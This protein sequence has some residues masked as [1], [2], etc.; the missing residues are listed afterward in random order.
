MSKRIMRSLT[1]LCVLFVLSVPT[2]AAVRGTIQNDTPGSIEAQAQMLKDLKLFKGTDKGLELEKPMTRAEAAVMVTR[3]LG[4][5]AEAK[6]QNSPHPFGDVPNWA[7]AYVGWLYQNGLTKGISKTEYGSDRRVTCQQFGVFLTRA[8]YEPSARTALTAHGK[9]IGVDYYEANAITTPE[10]TAACD[11]AGFLRSDAVA[12]AVRLLNSTYV[13]GVDAGDNVIADITV[14]QALTERNVFTRDQFKQAAWSVLNRV[15]TASTANGRRSEQE[16]D[17]A[18]SCVISG[19]PVLRHNDASLRYVYMGEE[20]GRLYAER[21]DQTLYLVNPNTLSLTEL[22]SGWGTKGFSYFGSI[23]QTDCFF[24]EGE[25]Y[26]VLTVTGTECKR[27]GLNVA[28]P[29][30]EP[31]GKGGYLLD[32]IGSVCQLDASGLHVTEAPT[33]QSRLTHQTDVIDVYE[34]ITAERTILSVTDKSGKQLGSY[35]I[36]NDYGTDTLYAPRVEG[37]K[38]NVLWG[39]VGYYQVIDGK[40]IQRVARP[41]YDFGT[42]WSDNSV[43][44]VTHKP[45]VRISY[46]AGRGSPPQWT[47]NQLIRV[48][49]DGTETQLYAE[50]PETEQPFGPLVLG[51]VTEASDNKISFTVLVPTEPFMTG[52]FS[53]V[54]ENGRVTV[55]GQTNDITWWYGD[56]AAQKAEAW[57]NAKR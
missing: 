55:K 1:A 9:K 25:P 49:A 23:G 38:N 53:C 34:D 57:L 21:G 7:S 50:P 54:L 24:I 33:T 26:D 37:V 31:D 28:A 30:A 39:G 15:Y 56:D 6:A 41:V 42:V 45:G 52:E 4:A 32:C 35:T 22:G 36:P 11:K 13:E 40:L 47:G 5:E 29:A 46:D 2:R 20:T 12:M 27:L 51:K 44:V 16:S 17:Y 18:I 48:A 10:E 14:A 3:L 8:S 43:V 19:V